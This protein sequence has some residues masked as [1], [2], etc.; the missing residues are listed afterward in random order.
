MKKLMLMAASLCAA[1][2]LCLGTQAASA[3]SFASKLNVSGTNGHVVHIF[4]SLK[5]AQQIGMVSPSNTSTC[6]F[7]ETCEQLAYG[8]GPV[9]LPFLNFYVIFWSPPHLQDGTGGPIPAAYQTIE[10]NMVAGYGGHA[11]AAID[12]QYY[13]KINNVTTYVEGM[14]NLV[15]SVVDT[16]AYPKGGCSDSGVPNA[17]N[18]I[19]DAQIQTEVKNVMA[20]HGW[21]GGLNKMFLVFTDQNEG[22]CAGSSCAYTAYCAYHSDFTSGSQVVVYSNEPYGNTSVCQVPG[23][24][25]PNGNPDADAATT[26][27]AH[28]MTEAI[29]D[30]EPASGWTDARGEEIGD[31]CAY[32]YGTNTWDSNKANQMWNG[33]F[34][35]IQLMYDNHRAACEQVGP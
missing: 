1:A 35:E 14:G 12:T 33:H 20:A 10:K 21:S 28:E 31:E 18:C 9:M 32:I 24:P 4:P 34:F 19:T 25:S 3:Q 29:T 17:S 22:S 26:S 13:Q 5:Y 2:A 8:G 6:A 7:S 23:A 30:P 11:L 27:A 15:N 16:T